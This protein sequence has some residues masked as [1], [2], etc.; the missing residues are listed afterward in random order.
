MQVSIGKHFFFFKKK[1]ASQNGY[2]VE[3]PT[4]YSKGGCRIFSLGSHVAKLFLRD[5]FSFQISILK[6]FE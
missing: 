3:I 6:K 1:S 4:S 5:F 2:N